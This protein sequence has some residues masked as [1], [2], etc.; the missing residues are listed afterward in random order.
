MTLIEELKA[1][2]TNEDLT[3]PRWPRGNILKFNSHVIILEDALAG[4]LAAG[5]RCMRLPTDQ[6]S[7]PEWAK[8]WI[9]YMFDAGLLKSSD[10]STGA[11]PLAA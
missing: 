9:P 10:I 1:Y 6:K 7:G 8:H 2:I 4:I 5:M 11:E 3:G